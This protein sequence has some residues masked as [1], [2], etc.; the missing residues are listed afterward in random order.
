MRNLT[1]EEGFS[2]HFNIKWKALNG[3]PGPGVWKRI[4]WLL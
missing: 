3:V 4:S 2:D 1:L